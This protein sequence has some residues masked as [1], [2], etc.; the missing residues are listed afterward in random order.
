[1]GSPVEYVPGEGL[2]IN[3]VTRIAISEPLLIFCHPSHL[4]KINI[5]VSQ[6]KT[7]WSSLLSLPQAANIV[8]IWYYF[9]EI[10]VG[11]IFVTIKIHLI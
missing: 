10:D 9:K 5:K 4:C 6:K 2:F 8:R 1:M 11:Q 3:Y 7:H